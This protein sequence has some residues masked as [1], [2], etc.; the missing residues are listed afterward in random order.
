M[1][2]WDFAVMTPVSRTNSFSLPVTL[3]FQHYARLITIYNSLFVWLKMKLFHGICLVVVYYFYLLFKWSSFSGVILGFA[4]TQLFELPFRPVTLFW[5]KTA[6]GQIAIAKFLANCESP[7]GPCFKW[8]LHAV[9]FSL[10]SLKSAWK[11]TYLISLQYKP[12]GRSIV[13]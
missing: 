7:A 5:A 2:Y 9:I 1:I 11:P 4:S 13:T 6:A 12:T 10:L 8:I 3:I